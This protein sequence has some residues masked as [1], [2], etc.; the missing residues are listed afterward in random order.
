MF[1]G[2]GNLEIHHHHLEGNIHVCIQKPFAILTMAAVGA[3]G[4]AGCSQ[5]AL[6]DPDIN[7]NF[8][9][10]G[11]SYGSP[12]PSTAQPEIDTSDDSLVAACDDYYDFDQE[13]AVEIEQVM[14]TAADPNASDADLAE[15]H[16]FTKEAR[17]EFEA[18][19]DD[20][21]HDEF[22]T[23]AEQTVPTLELFEQLTDPDLADE[24]KAALFDA[25]D[26]DAGVQ[27]EIDLVDLCT[28]AFN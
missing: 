27:A 16:E 17:A 24:E 13:Y 1:H 11:E 5:T 2:G 12:A 28:T 22:V 21:E 18:L 8:E 15:A 14:T 6:N 9:A 23:A 25:N 4:L 10:I 19:V 3:L 7:P 26:V 20:A